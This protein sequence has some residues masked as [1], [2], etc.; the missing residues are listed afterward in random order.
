MQNFCKPNTMMLASMVEVPPNLSKILRLQSLNITNCCPRDAKFCVS[1]GLPYSWE[2]HT[3]L[4][5]IYNVFLVALTF[6]ALDCTSG[7]VFL[8]GFMLDCNRLVT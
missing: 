7:L 2:R 4:Y 3:S 8:M 6:A 5:T 1:T